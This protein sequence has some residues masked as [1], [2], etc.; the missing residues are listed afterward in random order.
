MAT[1]ARPA[2]SRRALAA[3]LVVVAT[4]LAGTAGG[5]TGVTATDPAA[6][7]FEALPAN[8]AVDFA[9]DA[10]SPTFEF[11]SGVSAFRAFRLPEA[12]GPYYVELRSFVEG[13]PDPMRARV[14]YPVVALLSD[15]FLVSRTSELELLRFDLPVL[16]A[17][18]RPAYRLTLGIDPAHG[19][20]R[21]LVV[22]TAARLF[23]GRVLP[24][25]STPES[26]ADAARAAFL[27]AS[28]HGQLRITVR[29][30]G[31]HAPPE[32]GERR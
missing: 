25:I 21:Y 13:P 24:P 3:A 31:E 12:T 1:A 32:P 29:P 16:E 2:P 10:K 20:E 18:T 8:G 7:P 19:H 28:P 30:G 27:G 26:V 9:I 11:H 15:D 14:F 23:E 5:A 4:V 6:F 22:F 17:A